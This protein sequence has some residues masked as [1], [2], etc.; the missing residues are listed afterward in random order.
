M[1]VYKQRRKD[2]IE[3]GMRD[4]NNWCYWTW[5]ILKE[6]HLEHIWRSESIANENN[7]I[8]LV[9]ELIYRN[10]EEQW[11]SEVNKKSKLRTYRKLKDQLKLEDYVVEVERRK[12]RHLT[13]LRGGTNKLRIERGRW[14]GESEKERVCMVCLGDEVEDEKHFLLGCP[15]YV[16]ERVSM[17]EKI[18]KVERNLND[19]ERKE[20]D[21][22]L[23]I[24]IGRGGGEKNKQIREIVLDYMYKADR[25]RNRFIR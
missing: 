12:R 3:G 24:L 17:F 18:R 5:K 4:K 10:E 22:Q 7:F 16:C 19:I 14:R 20:E 23:D 13:M 15:R 8:K 9:R 6:L 1:Y 2:L 21:T 11:K 25:E